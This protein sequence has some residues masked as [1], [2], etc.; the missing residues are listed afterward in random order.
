MNVKSLKSKV[1]SILLFFVMI[2]ATIPTSIYA[3]NLDSNSDGYLL[4]KTADDFVEHICGLNYKTSNAKFKIEADIDLSTATNQNA[5]KTVNTEFKGI[6]DGGNHRISNLKINGRGIF[7]KLGKS[8]TIKNLVLEKPIVSAPKSSN[9]P[10]IVVSENDGTITDTFIMEG[11]LTSEGNSGTGMMVGSNKGT[12]QNS[13]VVG[14]EVLVTSQYS[15][16][17][18][19]GFVGITTG[20]IEECFSTANITG[21]KSVGG[22]AGCIEKGK[23]KNCY[24]MGKVTG[25]NEGIGGFVGGLKEDGTIENVYA[26]GDVSGL[27]GHWLI[28]WSGSS[29]SKLGTSVNSYF[30]KDK[31]KPEQTKIELNTGVLGKTTSEMR[32]TDFLNLLRGSSENIWGQNSDNDGF[33]TLVA[34]KPPKATLVAPTFES[35]KFVIADYDDS[36]FTFKKITEFEVTPTSEDKVVLDVMNRAK[37]K[38]LFTFETKD[39]DYGKYVTSIQQ[40]KAQGRD[41]W[42][43]TIDDE[44]S[45]LGIS[46]AKIS[47]AKTILWYRGKISNNYE[48]P[49]LAELESSVDD[50][51]II[52]S[53]EELIS[54]SKTA[55]KEILSKNYKLEKDIDLEGL[56]M[57]PIGSLDNPFTGNFSGQGHTISN[58]LINR[59]K[60]DKGVG[61]FGAIKGSKI[62]NLNIKNANITGGSVI[63]VLVG[64]AQVDKNNGLSNIIGNCHVS[65]KLNAGGEN[66]IKRTDAGGLVGISDGGI[67]SQTYNSAYTAIVKSSADVE[68]IADTGAADKSISGHVGGLVGYNKGNIIDSKATGDVTGGNTTGGLVGSTEGNIEK[69]SATGT[70]KGLFNIGGLAGAAN[71]GSSISNSFST[72]FVEPLEKGKG[73]YIGG[74]IGTASGKLENCISTGTVTLGWSYNGGF[75]GK[76]DSAISGLPGQIA[77]KNVAGNIESFT[78]EKLKPFG[79]FIKSLDENYNKAAESIAVSKHEAE[80]KANNEL[81]AN[82][83]KSKSDKI[84]KEKRNNLAKALK[85]KEDKKI[86]GVVDSLISQ[87][88]NK[89]FLHDK[90]AIDTARKS[91]DKLT[92]DQKKFVNELPLL[93]AEEKYQDI[94]TTGTIVFLKTA[95]NNPNI[96]KKDISNKEIS[97]ARGNLKNNLILELS[98]E[99]KYFDQ[100]YGKVFLNDVELVSP[101]DYTSRRGSVI[102]E[103][104]K[105]SLNRLK[106]GSYV[107][108]VQT[109]EGFGT[110]KINVK[111][112]DLSQ[113]KNNKKKELN[114][115]Q[116]KD[117]ANQKV[118][119]SKDNTKINEKFPGDKKQLSKSAEDENQGNMSKVQPNTDDNSPIITMTFI[120]ILAI[121]IFILVTQAKRKFKHD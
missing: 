13:A 69:C 31:S 17:N 94:S 20:N 57:S 99:Y 91:F 36:A 121:S 35:I 60:S 34:T 42:M 83:D 117:A 18:Q 23:V 4:I 103:L 6:L 24:S 44:L 1:F 106:V 90:A 48:G 114:T 46:S 62:T 5:I 65:G 102:I 64:H 58:L 52:K 108:K 10:A 112:A 70:V 118:N 63:G 54:L 93:K 19:G 39:S 76:I 67:D 9:S 120:L 71:T 53:K 32:S 113:N 15:I 26:S 88:P 59:D 75:A 25:N 45:K 95:E 110:I 96:N 50:F 22:F 100:T 7:K 28:G 49:K 116:N 2:F 86:A 37:E 104:N 81:S 55:D 29:F 66:F 47:D 33:P 92:E 21:I 85:E 43:F 78:G 105:N 84:L 80:D 101:Y 30:N 11:T 119:T 82:I 107:A 89:I 41:G 27:S 73:E 40:L 115:P 98:S 79:S 68:V 72:G 16:M 87:L 111:E 12:V 109:D 3:G 8:G 56:E 77:V 51:V 61:F 14:G 97:F 74:F 38:G